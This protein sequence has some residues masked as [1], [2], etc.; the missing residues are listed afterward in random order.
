MLA[1]IQ[2]YIVKHRLLDNSNRPVVVALSG[3]ADS[4]ALLAALSLLGY[5]CLAAHCNFHL[6]DEESDRDEQFA[7]NIAR[8]LNIPFIKTDFDTGN[9]ARQKRISVE[10]AARELRY[11]WFETLR[12]QKNA[13][14]IA[15]AHH[16]NDNAE[17]IL[18][19]LIRGTG[20]RGLRG[21]KPRNGHIIRPLLFTDK[22]EIL[23]WLATQKLTFVTDSSNLSESCTRNTIR[24]RILPQLREINP[25]VT[26]ALV[27]TS[28]HLADVELIY[29][30]AIDRARQMTMTDDSRINTDALLRLAA[31]ETLLYE[32]L[33]PYNFTATVVNDIFKTICRNE[34]GR[35]FY[36]PSHKLVSSHG[37]LQLATLSNIPPITHI[38]YVNKSDS[39]I[40]FGNAR[41]TFSIISIDETFLMPKDKHIACLDCD[42]LSFP[43][44]CRRWR[45]GDSFF[46]LGM[47]GRK[48]LSDFFTDLKYSRIDKDN[49]ILLCSG[50]DIVWIAGERIDNRY[51]IRPDTTTVLLVEPDFTL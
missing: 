9:H 26:D 31:P 3:G 35:T 39:R 51:R 27:R 14:A 22:D 10:M 49:A 1:S 29:T 15:V 48:K 46:P 18:L 16:K 34:A 7:C 30:E 21:M 50:Q 32:L 12:T 43:L 44:S 8:Q 13:Q 33:Q 17:T 11:Q 40:T 38:V 4:V 45:A 47:K 2:N 6:R 20:I 37:S 25:S 24:L 28:E 19:N 5:S 36:S 42:K 23:N 41:F